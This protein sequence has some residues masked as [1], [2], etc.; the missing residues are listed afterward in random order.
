MSEI[1]QKQL[2]KLKKKL[3]LVLVLVLFFPTLLTSLYGLSGPD[4]LILNNTILNFGITIACS[5]L[6]FIFIEVCESFLR[7][8]LIKLMSILL[9]LEIFSFIIAILDMALMKNAAPTSVLSFL[10][11]LFSISIIN[12]TPI[13]IATLLIIIIAYQLAKKYF[14]FIKKL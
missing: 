1:D 10:I 14:I 7:D 6:I 8:W 13:V 3:E 5:I 11:M 4:T 2:T 9:T 12:F